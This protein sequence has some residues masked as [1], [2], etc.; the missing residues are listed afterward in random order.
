[1]TTDTGKIATEIV[2]HLAALPH[3]DVR[4]RNRDRGRDP[5]RCA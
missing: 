4:I 1:M 2:Q 3:A 5:L